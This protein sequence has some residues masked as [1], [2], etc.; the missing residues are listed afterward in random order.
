MTN[1]K[2]FDE[3]LYSKSGMKI[4]T[5]MLIH[6]LY[7]KGVEP[8]TIYECV[9]STRDDMKEILGDCPEG[10]EIFDDNTYLTEKDFVEFFTYESDLNDTFRQMRI[11]GGIK[12]EV[13]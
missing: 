6:D 7:R 2:T 4:F 8:E 9:V 12:K 1:T 3:K 5:S 13:A 10:W 11:A